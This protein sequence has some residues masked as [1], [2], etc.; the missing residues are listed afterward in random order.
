MI[1]TD[2]HRLAQ[3][4]ATNSVDRNV[5]M[6]SGGFDP[7]H[8]GHVRCIQET[9]RIA[10]DTSKYPSSLKGT[11]VVVVNADSFLER[12]KGFAFMPLNERMEIISALEGVDHV[13]AWE[14][15]GDQTVCGAIEIL[16]PRYFT[17]GGDRTDF[18]NIP[19]W[20]V[21]KKIGCEILT[22]VGGGKIQSSSDLV[23][24]ASEL[25]SEIA[26]V[27]GYAIGFE[28]GKNEK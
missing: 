14:T 3:Y 8:I 15:E 12:K 28:D 1:W 16:K 25:E 13:V 21:C 6:T 20:A 19:E 22:N 7:L 10:T 11:V 26:E 17:K 5:Y 24:R 27:T 23:S 4:L 9:H 2:I 18:S